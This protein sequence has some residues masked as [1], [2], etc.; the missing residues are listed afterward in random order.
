L[1]SIK[2]LGREA[3]CIILVFQSLFSPL[4]LNFKL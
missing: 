2:K 1:L 4:I 3:F